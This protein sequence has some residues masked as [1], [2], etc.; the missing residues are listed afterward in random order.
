MTREIFQS[1]IKELEQDMLSMSEMVIKAINHSIGALKA[2]NIEEAKK[3]IVDDIFI[4]KKRWDIEEKC[5]SLIATQQPVA[6]DL[7]DII[8]IL[9][10]I[11][12]LER[13]GD[14]AKGIAKI[15]IKY[16]NGS[17]IKPLIDIPRMA[18]KTT[19]M[20]KR[21]IDAFIKRN[22]DVA[23]AICNED[24]EIDALYNQVYR[25]LL[26]FMLE[27]PR[28]IT[29]ATYLL[30]VAHN[31]EFSLQ[32]LWKKLMYLNISNKR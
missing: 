10:I 2:Q 1:H 31:L 13:M 28:V 26:T 24:D 21:S 30:W 3:I 9:N 29:R 5:I 15:T 25:E 32:V 6:S 18:E 8:V 16:G 22:A 27:D 4:N 19:D 23:R 7:R 20:L 12:N 14:H 11:T 17:L